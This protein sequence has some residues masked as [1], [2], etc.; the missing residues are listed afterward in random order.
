LIEQ[1]GDGPFEVPGTGVPRRVPPVSSR[2]MSVRS[3][4]GG[5]QSSGSADGMGGS[6]L[7]PRAELPAESDLPTRRQ[8]PE[9]DAPMRRTH[10][11]SGG[12]A[13]P[14]G[15]RMAASDDSGPSS[16]LASGTGS[17][18]GGD[19]DEARGTSVWR[20]PPGPSAPNHRA[21]TTRL[22]SEFQ[23]ERW[24]RLEVQIDGTVFRGLHYPL[25]GP[26]GEQTPGARSVRR[27]GLPVLDA[28]EGRHIREA[29]LD[30][31]QVD[32]VVLALGTTEMSVLARLPDPGP[33]DIAETRVILRQYARAV[34]PL[35]ERN[36]RRVFVSGLGPAL[37]ET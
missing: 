8:E 10:L 18:T 30:A 6:G 19:G 25:A 2:S 3:Q 37:S 16:S 5:S 33:L 31:R 35:I 32:F 20:R 36:V 26:L 22:P 24:S 27:A 12:R 34:R 11:P 1:I 4:P 14:A 7:N 21:P 9:S 15:A 28:Q 17:G 29:V 23:G 13:P